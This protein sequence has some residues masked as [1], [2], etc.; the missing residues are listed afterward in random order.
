M[1]E[2]ESLATFGSSLLVS[3]QQLNRRNQLAG[4]R[5]ETGSNLSRLYEIRSENGCSKMNID[6]CNG[7]FYLWQLGLDCM[8]KLPE[9]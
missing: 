6:C 2:F 7:L 5:S 9:A 4:P 1:N 3:I 8:R